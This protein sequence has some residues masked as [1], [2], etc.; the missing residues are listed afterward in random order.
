MDN[1]HRF[2]HSHFGIWTL[3]FILSSSSCYQ[4]FLRQQD[5]KNIRRQLHI[6]ASVT[7][8]SLDS[9]PKTPGFFGR[10][11][12]R[13]SAV[14][15]FNRRQFDRYVRT[16]DDEKIWKPVRFLNYSPRI[17]DE[18]SEYAL[19]W[20]EF[21][22][23]PWPQRSLSHWQHW[24]EVLKVSEGKYFCSVIAAKQEPRAGHTGG[25]NYKGWG[26]QGLHCSEIGDASGTITTFAALDSIG[27]KLFVIVAFSG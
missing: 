16:L 18:Y 11:G 22:I 6:P 7:I 8:V 21:P 15:Q 19:Q 2:R 25:G 3:A 23:H 10:E 12:L 9:N 14:F 17:A 20:K 26:Y 13:I 5:E 24:N 4:L 1:F 27:R